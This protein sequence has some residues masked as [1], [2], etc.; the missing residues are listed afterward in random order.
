M[1]K[2]IIQFVKN[3]IVFFTSQNTCTSVDFLKE[4][5]RSVKLDVLVLYHIIYHISLSSV[6]DL[7][8][9]LSD[10]FILLQLPIKDSLSSPLAR[11]L[12]LK[13]NTINHIIVT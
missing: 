1:N 5:S 9:F 7:C 2:Y 12:V 3:N 6:S 11:S 8:N 13:K 10:L 4:D